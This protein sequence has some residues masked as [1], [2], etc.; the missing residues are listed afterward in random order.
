MV[1]NPA[2]IIIQ[3]QLD[4]S[5]AQEGRTTLKGKWKDSFPVSSLEYKWVFDK[6]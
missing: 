4:R 5:A 3:A 1:V 6:L 2:A